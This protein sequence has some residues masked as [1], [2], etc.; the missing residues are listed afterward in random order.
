MKIISILS[1]IIFSL[2]LIMGC[3]GNR[4][5]KQDSISS[6]DT[7]S[8]PDTGYTGIKQYMSGKYKVSEVTFKN[9]IKEGLKKTFYQ[10]GRL[11]QTFIYKNNLRVDSSLWYYPEGQVFRSTP[12]KRDTADGIQRQYYRNGKIKARIGYKNGLRTPFIEEFTQD[13][14]LVGGYPE[15]VIDF[16]DDYKTRGVYQISLELSDKSTK[17]RYY[18]G[19]FSGGVFDTAHCEKI[20]TVKGV[21]T[22]NLKKTGSSTIDNVGVIAEILTAYGNN[23]LVNK[24]ITLPYNDLK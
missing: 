13:G 4:S 3:S 6:V 17:V 15:L 10:D 11:R 12:Y 2:L 24:K 20:K 16:R 8:V 19:D 22:L 23:Y 21:G 14:K 1:S 9:G 5:T 18:R 7:T